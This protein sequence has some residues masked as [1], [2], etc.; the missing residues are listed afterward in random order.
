MNKQSGFTLVELSLVILIV[1]LITASILAGTTLVRQAKLNRITTD[2]KKYQ[3]AALTFKEKYK[4]YPGDLSNAASYWPSCVNSGGN[5]CNGNGNGKIET[6]PRYEDIR[7]WQHLTLAGLIKGNYSGVQYG[8]GSYRSVPGVNTPFG[9]LDRSAYTTSSGTVYGK[10]GDLME[11]STATYAC[12]DFAN[13]AVVSAQEAY[14]IDS[15]IDDGIADKGILY[16][17]KAV[18]TGCAEYA[19]CVANTM[20]GATSG[21]W[22]FSV[23]TPQCRLIYW[24]N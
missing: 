24:L 11:F 23:S 17:G 19:G 21:N 22:N 3:S 5:T 4:T 16:A 15:K 13:D 18:T 12:N 9:S 10:S 14:A 2:A 6:F 1:G 8:A 7:F 20:G